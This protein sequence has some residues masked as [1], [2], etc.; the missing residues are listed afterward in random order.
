MIDIIFSRGSRV[1][2]S[3]FAVI[4]VICI[5]LEYSDIASSQEIPLREVVRR[6]D[7]VAH[8]GP[9]VVRAANFGVSAAVKDLPEVVNPKDGAA[10]LVNRKYDDPVVRLE[11]RVKNPLNANRVKK[12]VS[13][14]NKEGKSPFVDQGLSLVFPSVMPTPGISSEGLSS[15]DNTAVLG[16]TFAPSDSIGDVGPNHYVQMSNT[17]VRVFNKD[18]TPAA[19]PFRLSSLTRVIGGPCANVDDGDPIVNYDPLADRWVLSQFCTDPDPGHQL[20]AVSKTSDPTGAYYV[21]DF[22]HPNNKFQD[23]PQIA[24]WPEAYYMSANQFVGDTYSGAGAFAYDRVKMLQGDP[25]ASYIYFDQSAICPTCGGQLPTD[26]DGTMTPPEGMG[27]LFMEFRATEFG[28]PTDGL[29]IFEFKANFNTPTASTFTQVGPD[30]ALAAFDGNSPVSRSCVEQPG[31]STGLDCVA[32]RMMHRLA[33]RNLG[34][35]ASPVNSWVLNFTV[36]VGGA[37]G[38]SMATYQAGIRWVELRRPGSAGGLTVNQQ[39]TQATNPGTPAGGTNLWMG[40]IAQDASGNI[41]LGYSTSGSAT[42]DDFPSIKYSGRLSTDP[43]N[44]MGQGEAV[45]HAGTGFQ[46]GAGSRWGDYSSASVDP[47][48]ECTFW[49]TQG[50][51]AA[52]HNSFPFNWTTRIIGGIRFPGCSTPERGT[53][54]GVVSACSSGLPVSNALVSL[55]GGFVATTNGIGQYTIINVPVGVTSVSA[56][57]SGGF[58]LVTNSGIS[59]TDATT[60]GVDLCLNGIPVLAKETSTLIS[61]S[62]LP[63]NGIIDPGETVTIALPVSNA[64]AANTVDSVGT[65]QATGG[66]TNPGSAQSYGAMSAGGPAVTR[67]FTFTADAGLLCGTNLTVTVDHQ[68]GD[69]N[70]GIIVYTLPT[71]AT[72]DAHVASYTGPAVA[73]PDNDPAGVNISLAVSGVGGAAADIDF[74]F[75]VAAEGVC[76]AALGNTNAAMDHTFIGDLNFR[77]TSPEGTSVTIMSRR[78][79]SRDNICSTLLDDDGGFASLS[80]VSSASGQFLSGNFAPD[81]PLS[82]FDG[83]NPNGIWVLNISDNA[84]VDTGSMRRFS[85]VITP[86]VCTM[87]AVST[88]TPSPSLSPTVSPTPT[89]SPPAL[90]TVSGRVLTPIG[91]GLRNARVR[92][93]DANGMSRTVLTSTLGYYS[94]EGVE[95]GTTVNIGVSSRQYRFQSVDVLVTVGMPEVDFVG[96]E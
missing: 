77:L 88:P 90:I 89:P 2:L 42:P 79:G 9:I 84:G 8:P 57:K 70:L 87:C 80:T 78:G 95:T 15:M 36:N 53:I 56:T 26:L 43:P 63:A 33:Y 28:D 21:Y 13:E 54:S 76:N 96:L 73:V 12:R 48:D 24:V 34:T 27:N 32:D 25:G 55:P 74:R 94:F 38:S 51:R 39:G 44:T 86:R 5:F 82:A 14:N 46:T 65:L 85:L 22:V 17:L 93:F 58:D 29:R 18:G 4:A 62:C 72:G 69:K 20:F 83:Q 41:F 37:S 40:S 6:A 67:N 71:G 91:N 10:R 3:V 35:V 64:G 45:G 68:D 66:V 19:A 1:V 50:Y 81:N 47:S 30:L 16:T 59:V 92:M 75:D 61:E 60:T 11:P 52:A 23:Y 49:Y 31:T 7:V